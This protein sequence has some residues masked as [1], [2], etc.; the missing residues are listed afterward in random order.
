MIRN[1]AKFDDK[2]LNKFAGGI[3][4]LRERGKWSKGDVLELYFELLPDF[5]HKE[6]GKYLDQRM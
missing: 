4:A 1:A 3:A 5:M 2:S 6:M